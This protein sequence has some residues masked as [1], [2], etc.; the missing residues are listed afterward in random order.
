MSNLKALRAATV[1]LEYQGVIQHP[2]VSSESMWADAT[3]NDAPTIDYWGETWVKN[4]EENHKRFGPFKANPVGGLYHKFLHKPAI[5]AGSGPSLKRNAHLLKDRGD[6]PLVSCLHNF[7]YFEDLDAN[8]DYYCTLDAGEVTVEEVYE[9]GVHEPEYYWEKTKNRTLVAFIGTSP[10]LI[11]KW[12]GKIIWF[13]APIPN[14]VIEQKIESLEPFNQYLSNGG[15]V[16][17]ACLYLAKGILGCGAI[18]FIG[19]DFSF[20]YPEIEESKVRIGFHSWKSKYDD[21]L[22][23][24]MRVTDVYGNKVPTWLSYYNFKKFFDHVSLRVPGPW[25]N[26]TEGGCLGAYPEGNIASFRYCDLGDWLKE[27]NIS[28]L[29]RDSME[30]P[31]LPIKKILY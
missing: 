24:Y 22:G 17:G 6:L 30:N 12:Q 19:A 20:G 7:H 25:I 4:I 31:E 21:K 3:R 10:R 14:Q 8:V 1:L 23:S 2:P 5:I 11:E 28:E 27:V 16:L 9:G 26:C 13:N 15:N 29:I 18:A